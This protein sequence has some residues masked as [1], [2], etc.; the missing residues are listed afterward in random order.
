MI[1]STKLTLHYILTFEIKEK[2]NKQLVE[3]NKQ[4][5]GLSHGFLYGEVNSRF[6]INLLVFTKQAKISGKLMEIDPST[7][8]VN[9]TKVGHYNY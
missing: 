3:S 6:L 5:N 8:I 1:E 2:C 9:L 7:T 4:R